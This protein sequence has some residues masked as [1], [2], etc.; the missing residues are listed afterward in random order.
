MTTSQ[1]VTDG[2]S[3]VQTVSFVNVLMESSLGK[4]RVKH[5]Y[6]IR[7]RCRLRR[8]YSLLDEEYKS[9]DI[10]KLLVEGYKTKY[11]VIDI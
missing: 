5:N 6:L 10:F 3:K 9:K 2:D 1:T 11:L 7:L 4:H 8:E